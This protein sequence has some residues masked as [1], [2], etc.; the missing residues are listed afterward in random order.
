MMVIFLSWY[1]HIVGSG[2]GFARISG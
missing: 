1:M 2:M